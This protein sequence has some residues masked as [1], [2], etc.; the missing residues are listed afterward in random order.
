MTLSLWNIIFNLLVILKNY[1]AKIPEKMNYYMPILS[2]GFLLFIS[3]FA[4]FLFIKSR[5]LSKILKFH[6]SEERSICIIYLLIIIFL[7]F[8][9]V[10]YDDTNNSETYGFI[11]NFV[12]LIILTNILFIFIENHKLKL[13][14]VVLFTIISAYRLFSLITIYDLFEFIKISIQIFTNLSLVFIFLNYEKT[15]KCQEFKHEDSKKKEKNIKR[16]KSLFL[17]NGNK[18]L[19]KFLNSLNSGILL[20]DKDMELLFFNRKMKRFF[21]KNN[22]NKNV[23]LNMSENINGLH[24]KEDKDMLTENLFKLKNIKCYFPEEDNNLTEI[25]VN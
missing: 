12:T 5:N 22:E 15:I 17:F 8:F 18:I 7:S 11:M 20:Y 13:V 10:N 16:T 9:P 1:F 25:Q 3:C 14:L 19:F 6:I 2:M 24:E 23:S 4:Y 21:Y